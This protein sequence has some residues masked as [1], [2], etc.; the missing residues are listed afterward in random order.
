ML[1]CLLVGVDEQFAIHERAVQHLPGLNWMTAMMAH[2]GRRL[3]Y[4][5]HT[6]PT[7]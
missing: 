7:G 3:T 6:L 5:R 2:C 4:R 1:H